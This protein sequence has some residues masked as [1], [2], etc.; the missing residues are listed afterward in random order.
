M[1]IG[2]LENEEIKKMLKY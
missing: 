1:K 2:N